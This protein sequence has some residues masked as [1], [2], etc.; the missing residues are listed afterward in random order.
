MIVNYRIQIMSMY[1]EASGFL[2][3]LLVVSRTGIE[4]VSR[5]EDDIIR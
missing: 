5:Q 2:L 3:A 4:S 1:E